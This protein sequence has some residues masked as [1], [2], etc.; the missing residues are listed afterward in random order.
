[1]PF[2]EIEK[3]FDPKTIAIIGANNNKDSVGYFVFENIKK[4]DYKGKVYPVNIEKKKVQGVKA[5][6]SI[7]DVPEKIDLVIIATP[8][9]TVSKIVEECGKAGVKGIV[10]ISSG[11]KEAGEAG[12]EMYNKI[13][14]TAKKYEMRVMGPNCLGFIKPSIN[15][16]ATF[17]AR[18][19]R[20][21]SIAFIS[22]SGALCTAI[23]DWAIR[24]N[25]GFRY[26]VSIG[27]MVD[28]GFNDLIDYFGRDPKVKSILIYMESLADSRKFMSAAR[29]FSRN[30]PIIVLKAGKS[31]EGAKATLSHTGTLAGNDLAFDAAFRRVGAVR[32]NTIDELFDYAKALDMQRRPEGNKLAVITNAGGP[33]VI[34]TDFLIQKGGE[35][36]KL[37]KESMNYLNEKLPSTWSKGNPVDILGDAGPDRYREA[38]K[39]CINDENVEGILVILTPQSMTRAEEVAKEIVRLSRKTDKPILVAWMGGE[40]IEKGR[41]SLEK[42]SIPTYD[43]PEAAIG[44]F[45][46]MYKYSRNLE[47]L[48]ETPEVIPRDF[49]PDREKAE[50]IIDKVFKSKKSSLNLK[51]SKELLSCYEIPVLE[52]F[53]VKEKKDLSR[54]LKK[55]GYPVVIKINSSKIAH[56]TETGGVKLNVK[57]LKQAKESFDQIKKISK[58]N[59][60]KFE[61]VLVEKM[62]SDGHELLIGA[63]KDDLFGP[64]IIFGMGGIAVEVFKDTNIGLPPLNMALATRVIE[65]T[66]IYEL[67]K[68][69]RGKKGVDLKSIKFLLYKF[70]YLLMDFPEIKEVDI[71]PFFVDQ[72][73]GL[74]LDALIVLDKKYKREKRDPYSHLVISPYPK[75]YIKESRF[76]GGKKVKLRPI[77]PEDEP[78]EAGLF[79]TFSD[80]TERFRF[81]RRIGEVG[82]DFLIN[83]TQID[84]DREIAIIAEIEE[85]GKKKMI[86]VVR[87]ISDPENKTAEYAIVVGDPWQN[88]G[89]G[90]E[91]TNHILKI[92]K[93]RG[94][95][96]VYATFL[97]DNHIMRRMLAKRNFDIK[98]KEDSYYAEK[99]INKK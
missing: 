33:G 2:T 83:Y 93:K 5:Y 96:K 38:L 20:D 95:E 12:K 70:S 58:K 67:L 36:S 69:I 86:G 24:R 72:K 30:K 59:K 23:L 22:Q 74:V 88:E 91:L 84:Y 34:A 51:E 82:H 63:K 66:K 8:A 49:S 54:A 44:C 9:K 32:V 97:R 19:P 28:I 73:K 65:Q 7:T 29:A 68:G 1:M 61:G 14:E 48:Y 79:K 16:N 42:G 57:S 11:F 10:I 6:P 17:S 13:S 60:V 27:S 50:K 40:S 75:E 81:F 26:F 37:S 21:G 94:I 90:D 3:L 35:L 87:L 18:V 80:E 41:V 76:K 56:K 31:S 64:I 99:I 92:A 62:M 55:T 77:R 4:S 52:S 78:L 25:V 43:S 89:L 45:L 46:G 85:G 98:R 47:L 71:N 15:L 53:L 39:T